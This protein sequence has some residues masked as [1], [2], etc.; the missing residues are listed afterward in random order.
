MKLLATTC[1]ILALSF[2]ASQALTLKKGDVIGG[3]GQVYEGASPELIRQIIANSKKKD[4][5]GNSQTAGVNGSNLYVV[6]EDDVTFIP[7]SSLT[8]KS[9]SEI[10][11]IVIESVM[12]DFGETIDLS[13]AQDSAQLAAHVEN[14]QQNAAIAEA[15][16]NLE[17]AIGTAQEAAAVQAAIAVGALVDTTPDWAEQCMAE[18]GGINYETNSCD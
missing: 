1:A 5:F 6:V 4:F 17:A 14:L 8:G 2:S 3:D 15:T 16:Q 18:G 7:I 12:A 13:D 10:Q 9:K 11:A